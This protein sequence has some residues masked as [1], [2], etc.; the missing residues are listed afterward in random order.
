M[1]GFAGT[2]VF[3]SG[4]FRV[5]EAY[6]TQLR[7]TMVHRGPDGAGTWVD[8]DGRVGLGHRRL[9]IVD[10]SEAAAQPMSDGRRWL[11][12]NGEIYNH[13]EIRTELRQ[14]GHSRWQTDHSDTE[15]L[16]HAFATWGIECLP[17][18]R[19]MFAFALW[20]AATRELWLVRDRIGVK[21]LYYTVRDDRIVFASEI[22]ALLADPSQPRAVDEE[23]LHHY[24]SF[25]ATPAPHTLFRGIH[26]LAGGTWLRARADGDVRVE[27]YW[28]PWDHAQ[29]I[30]G[31]DAEL[32]ARVLDELREAVRL[33][34]VSD[35]P[36]G[37]FLSGGIDSS[38]TAALFA[39]GETRPI[40]TFTAGYV[41]DHASYRNETEF[42][43]TMADSI[44]AEHHEALLTQDDLL[45]FL[46]RL[47]ELQDEPIADPVC[48]PVYYL[49]KLARACG[50]VVCQVGEGSD[51]LFCGY[52]GWGADLRAQ[53]LGHWPIPAWVKRLGLAGMAAI[54]K[55]ETFRY[56]WLR[57]SLAGEP[58][59][60]SAAAGFTETKKQ[61]LLA[62]PV[63]RRLSGLTSFDALADVR[64]RFLAKA[65]EPSDLN[66]MTTA[67]LSLRLPELL[68]MRVDKMTMGASLE[69][70][71]PFLD[72]R[73]V[74]LALS[75]PTAVKLRGDQRKIVLKRAVRG[76]IPDA[77]IDRPKQGFGVPVREWL[78][79]RLGE[80][81]RAEVHR[82]A[83][84][85]G[86]LDVEAAMQV[87]DHGRKNEPWYLLNLALW[88]KHYI[89]NE[90][91]D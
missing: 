81:A 6:V 86:L 71:V 46:P 43:R 61:R 88:W 40:Q 22:K 79:D 69:A 18:L 15:V 21:P 30:E 64:R 58:I 91:M 11:A 72:H 87:F 24:L 29:R 20:D 14:L 59:F 13:A 3:D 53:R 56:E 34:K 48:V 57:R 80:H 9:A 68:L 12:Y 32:S 19:G 65:W 63:A 54:G 28:D 25:L 33:R 75:L 41:G 90:P 26:K 84:R 77:L 83:A 17:R 5:T 45:D 35:V 52:D 89:A 66:W 76:L 1:C 36:V 67:E 8:T 27:R 78:M 60:W 50:V 62:P 70:R 7:E 49:A 4:H 44:G 73:F 42:A 47:I 23:A 31:S 85:S 51:E 39:E 10:L 55:D 37:V 82:F 74:E 2:F 38:T 16:L